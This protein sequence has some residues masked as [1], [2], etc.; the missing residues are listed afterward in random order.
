MQSLRDDDVKVR[1]AAVSALA[2][3]KDEVCI[4]ALIKSLGD[5]NLE[6]REKVL[7]TISVISGEEI[8]FD[9]HNSGKALKNAVAELRSWWEDRKLGELDA[10]PVVE[11]ETHDET[12][13]EIAVE[14]PDEDDP[15][16]DE[17]IPE[18][19]AEVV[20]IEADTEEAEIP[21]P[22]SKA[23]EFETEAP[24][25]DNL[26]DYG[27]IPETGTETAEVETDT[28][29]TE[30]AETKTEAENGET[31]QYTEHQLMRMVK[32]DLMVICDDLGIEY[33]DAA[34]KAELSMLILREKN[35]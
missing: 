11:T 32:S 2:N 16:D 12:A 7:E 23:D 18:T 29:V 1:K 3:I 13:D 30:T 19:D 6:I 25:D 21:E 27:K 10:D 20:E 4:P 35:A 28:E 24:D 8:E 34:T 9:V 15:M 33:D 14:T 5:K 17:R 31:L 26:M 22:E